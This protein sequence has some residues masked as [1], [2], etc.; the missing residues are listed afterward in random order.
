MNQKLITHVTRLRAELAALSLRRAELIEHSKEYL[1]ALKHRSQT[2]TTQHAIER[3]QDLLTTLR[4][5]S[6]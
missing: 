5:L 6:I 1:A 3:T 2:P 4:N